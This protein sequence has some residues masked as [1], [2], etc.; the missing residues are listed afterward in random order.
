[1]AEASSSGSSLK[2]GR[3]LAG[4]SCS[5]SSPRNGAISCTG[6]FL[7]SAAASSPLD[8][9]GRLCCWACGREGD[10]ADAT[11]GSIL[12]LVCFAPRR[13]WGFLGD[14]ALGSSAPRTRLLVG[15]AV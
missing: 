7:G 12:M 6:R 8:G 4:S 9:E 5:F 13:G 10:L 14:A 15:D 3:I 1:M 2:Q 11:T